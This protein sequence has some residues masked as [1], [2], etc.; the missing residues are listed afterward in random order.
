VGLSDLSEIEERLQGSLTPRQRWIL[1]TRRQAEF[2]TPV[3][4]VGEE[5][6]PGSVDVADP[7]PNQETRIA[8][9]EQQV[10]LWKTVASLSAN[11]RLL[12]QFR[13]EQELSLDEI[14]RLCGL[15]DAQRAHRWL[16]AVLKKLRHAMK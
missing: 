11:E 8:D 15:R 12:L 10:R 9:Q 1:G 7:S 3:A 13:F 4:V 16:A 6:E 14:A 2:T 5:D